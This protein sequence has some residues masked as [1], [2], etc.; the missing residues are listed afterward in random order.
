MQTQHEGK[1]TVSSLKNTER[2]TLSLSFEEIRYH[3]EKQR[4]RKWEAQ[5]VDWKMKLL[6][7][8]SSLKDFFFFNQ[9]KRIISVFYCIQKINVYRTYFLSDPFTEVLHS[10]LC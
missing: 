4:K 7:I 1:R 10:P 6:A 8:V 9:I 2:I 3:E 5:K